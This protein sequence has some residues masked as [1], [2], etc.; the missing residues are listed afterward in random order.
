MKCNRDLLNELTISILIM[1]VIYI[2]I[3]VILYATKFIKF[4]TNNILITI[5]FFVLLII[6]AKLLLLYE[7]NESLEKGNSKQK[8]DSKKDTVEKS[9][10]HSQP[11]DLAQHQDEVRPDSLSSNDIRAKEKVA[12]ASVGSMEKEETTKQQQSKHSTQ[13]TEL[14]AKLKEFKDKNNS[15]ECGLD[16]HIDTLQKWTQN[17]VGLLKKQEG[18]I[19]KIV[20]EMKKYDDEQ[21]KDLKEQIARLRESEIEY[22]ACLT[23]CLELVHSNVKAE[24]K[25]I[26]DSRNIKH[27]QLFQDKVH[28]QISEHI[29]EEEK[30]VAEL[31]Q[32]ELQKKEAVEQVNRFLILRKS[33]IMLNE[34]KNY[35]DCNVNIQQF[36]RRWGKVGVDYNTDMDKLILGVY[37]EIGASLAVNNQLPTYVSDF[38]NQDRRELF[39]KFIGEEADVHNQQQQSNSASAQLP[40]WKKPIINSYD[41]DQFSDDLARL[42]DCKN[43]ILDRIALCEK[44]I[45][46]HKKCLYQVLDEKQGIIDSLLKEFDSYPNLKKLLK[47]CRDLYKNY[48]ESRKKYYEHCIKCI[49]ESKN[50]YLTN[51]KFSDNDFDKASNDRLIII[52]NIYGEGNKYYK[53]LRCAINKFRSALENKSVTQAV[54]DQLDKYR[55]YADV[56]SYNSALANGFKSQ[57]S[58]I[59]ELK[60]CVLKENDIIRKKKELKKAA[61]DL[62][63]IRY[64]KPVAEVQAI[65]TVRIAKMFY[66]AVFH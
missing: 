15:L 36:L 61:E 31:E 29:R 26:K 12:E 11:S 13:D 40:K 28:S 43:K 45:E 62:V 9:V 3:V 35:V 22:A 5:G 20:Q 54:I 19:N 6:S 57:N 44:D 46:E 51:N 2:Q 38:H 30:V 64:K 63:N 10:V 25:M 24:V 41:A 1:L 48:Y 60:N 14:I 32:K 59:E 17:L 18:N 8:Q 33:T 66:R 49:E 27:L 53:E 37:N 34:F 39:K 52:D 58:H 50:Y 55:D 16:I 21:H 7:N 56:I 23:K 47:N 42:D 65:S 4:N